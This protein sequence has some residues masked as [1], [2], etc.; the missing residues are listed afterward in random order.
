MRTKTEIGV[1]FQLKPTGSTPQPVIRQKLYEA[2]DEVTYTNAGITLPP[3]PLEQALLQECKTTIM[4][5]AISLATFLVESNLGDS[6]M[7]FWQETHI[8]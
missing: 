4:M 2:V 7:P 3:T 5:G 1:Q 8:P 6:V